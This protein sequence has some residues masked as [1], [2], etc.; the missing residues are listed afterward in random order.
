MAAHVRYVRRE[1]HG[2]WQV[3][4]DMVSCDTYSACFA[5]DTLGAINSC[6]NGETHGPVHI[7]SGGEWGDPEEDFIRT[8][9][10]MICDAVALVVETDVLDDGPNWHC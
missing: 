10:G 4:T 8:V 6:L 1:L 5:S 7:L 2:F 9:G 3:A